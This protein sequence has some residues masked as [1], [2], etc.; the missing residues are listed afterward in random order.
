MLAAVLGL[1]Q[2][3]SWGTLYYSFPLIVLRMQEEL[4][5]TRADL[6]AGAS[7]GLAM[8]ALLSY[9][10]GVG[11]DRGH[12]KWIMAGCSFGACLILA[13][14]SVTDSLLAFYAIC[15]LSGAMQAGVLYEPSFA[16]LA[17]RV[18]PKNARAGITH[19]TLWGGFASTAFVPIISILIAMYDWRT[20]LLFLGAVNLTYGAIYLIAIQPQKDLG[21]SSNKEQKQADIARDRG[22]V[23]ENLRS[24]LFWLLLITL[25]VYAGT[26]SAFTFHM[27]PL[28]EE[29]GLSPADVVLAIA[30]IGPAQVLGRILVTVYAAGVPLRLLGAAIVTVFP[31]AFALLLPQNIGFWLV[32]A[33][34][35]AY[36]LVNGIFTII[37]SFMVPEMLSPHAYGAL[38]GI[39][40]VA[41]TIAR[42]AAP[43]MAAW[44]WSLHQSYQPVI[45]AIVASSLVLVAGFWLAAWRS[46]PT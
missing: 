26:F 38:N 21:H 44:I 24:S 39:I 5:W 28:L 6:Y 8:T 2:I 45:L 10:V 11:I 19:I 33:V 17:R 34:F 23:Q 36:G 35:A 16:V 7:I 25:T 29:K 18:G 1:G 31:I 13:W 46:R 43:L 14:W 3:C 40:T 42:A 30:I 4:G 37:R 15:A 22:I 32:A 20:T 41:A 12:G 27:Y 9:P